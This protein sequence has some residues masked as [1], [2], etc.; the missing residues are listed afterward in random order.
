MICHFYYS[1][2]SHRSH[3]STITSFSGVST[4]A[5]TTAVLG[6]SAT[7]PVTT[8]SSGLSGGALAGVVI[9]SI[10]GA[11]LLVGIGVGIGIVLYRKPFNRAPTVRVSAGDELYVPKEAIQ[12][13]PV[14]SE[15]DVPKDVPIV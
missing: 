3:I 4:P 11:A 14:V 12:M 1:S 6:G 13:V 15:A 2:L 10:F 5:I 7:V 8:T 9:G